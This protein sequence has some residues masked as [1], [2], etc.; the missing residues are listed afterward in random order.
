MLF[1]VGMISF[2][3]GEIANHKNVSH[4][5]AYGLPEKE[6]ENYPLKRVNTR[7][8][9]IFHIIGTVSLVF[10]AMLFVYVMI[11]QFP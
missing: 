5:S 2:G 7:V 3:I 1:G 4:M 9:L 8:G 6:L 11:S 10:G